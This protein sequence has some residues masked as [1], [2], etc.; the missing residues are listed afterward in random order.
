MTLEGKKM[1]AIFSETGRFIGY[2]DFKPVEGLYKEMPDGFNPVDQVYVGTYEKGEIKT[3]GELKPLDYRLGNIDKKWV[4]YEAQLNEETKRNIIEENNYTL[5]RQLN[6]ITQALYEN[7]DK[8]NLSKDFLHMAEV[9]EDVRYRHKI[10]IESYEEM[11]KNGQINY[12]PV[13][14]EEEYMQKYT[15]QVLDITK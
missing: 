3:I 14:T 9:I 8:L 13:G 11:A 15:E 5:H 7:K 6:L 10:S 12:V 2:V 4:I 1:Y